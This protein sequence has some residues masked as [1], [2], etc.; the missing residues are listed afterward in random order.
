MW[1]LSALT[2]DQ[3]H[4]PPALETQ[5]LNHWTARESLDIHLKFL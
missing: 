2:R 3:T 4:T 5:S 1:D